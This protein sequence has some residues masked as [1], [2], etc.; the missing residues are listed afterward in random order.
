MKID[1]HATHGHTPSRFNELLAR[2][3]QYQPLLELQNRLRDS[4]D[5]IAISGLA[6]SAEAFLV[7]GL[8]RSLDRPII[9]VTRST[10][11]AAEL[12][13]DLLFLM[14]SERLAFYPS[15]QI[16]PYDFKAPVGEI[17]GQRISTLA[18]MLDNRLSVIVCPLRALMEPT[19]PTKVLASSRV[20]IEVGR[21]IDVEDLVERLVQLGFRR[22]P[23]VEE[24]GDFA[25]RGGLIDLF[26][27]GSEYPVRVELF[28]D[29]VETIRYF[30]VGNQR[31]VG[32]VE[33]VTILPKR[34]I[35][36]TQETLETELGKLPE[37]DADHIRHRYLNDPE[38][39][40]LEWLSILFGLEQG[41]LL[42]FLPHNAVVLLENE[43][44]LREEAEEVILEAESLHARLRER[45]SQL[46]LPTEYYLSPESLFKRLEERTQINH[47]PFR[48]ARSDVISFNCQPHPAFNARLD[49]LGK[50][51]REYR[52]QQVEYVITT[53]NEG[54][55]SRLD[56]LIQQK[57]GLDELPHVEVISLRAGF[58]CPDAGFVVLTDHELFSR[59]HR[60]IRRKKFKEGVAISDYSAL[61]KGDY[62]VHT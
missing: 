54:Q 10:D 3:Q 11:E 19:I 50:A 23:L 18:G 39:P 6:G 60:R 24:V 31:T 36:I 30:E 9:I 7:N 62:V 8:A 37:E 47:L 53:D 38:L 26:T 43:E 57:A 51:I 49:L 16:L 59:H 14:N 25:R 1:T 34:E 12:H 61:T 33:R 2:W 52:E 44:A 56:E 29:T 40:G 55:A 32:Q 20:D 22:V 58:G 27:P 46:P 13:E 28:G 5:R 35:P 41:S 48:G 21:E 4:R 15:R 45:L 17:M 42:D